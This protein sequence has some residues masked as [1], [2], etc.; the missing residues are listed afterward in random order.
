MGGGR[1]RTR[2]YE[3]VDACSESVDADYEL[4]EPEEE[5]VPADAEPVGDEFEVVGGPATW[6]GEEAPETL[7]ALEAIARREAEYAECL[8]ELRDKLRREGALDEFR[9]RVLDRE[10][11]YVRARLYHYGELAYRVTGG[12]CE[13][14][15]AT[16]RDLCQRA[17]DGVPGYVGAA[18][19]EGPS[20]PYVVLGLLRRY[21]PTCY[22]RIVGR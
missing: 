5:P 18:L 3:V 16:L 6:L 9:R 21:H 17:A 20:D 1:A 13:G 4:P 12:T 19:R 8:V 10:I 14:L 22:S 2:R 11:R 7:R 15:D